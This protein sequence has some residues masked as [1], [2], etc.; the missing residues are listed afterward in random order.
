MTSHDGKSRKAPRKTKSNKGT[1]D[2]ITQIVQTRSGDHAGNR[3]LAF[4][5]TL[6][7]GCFSYRLSQASKRGD[8]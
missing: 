5:P 3:F 6:S 1:K 7:N 2:E 4:C 8:I